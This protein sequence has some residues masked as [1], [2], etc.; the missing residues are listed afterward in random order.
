MSAAAH[1]THAGAA[2][3][4]GL[5]AVAPH[6]NVWDLLGAA[7]AEDKA[8]VEGADDEIEGKKDEKR[9]YENRPCPDAA[10][11][12]EEAALIDWILGTCV[13]QGVAQGAGGARVP[14]EH[15]LEVR[16]LV[17]KDGRAV[18]HV[19]TQEEDDR[20]ALGAICSGRVV[21]AVYGR[22]SRAIHKSQVIVSQTCENRIRDGSTHSRT[23]SIF[24]HNLVHARSR[25]HS[26]SVDKGAAHVDVI[27]EVISLCSSICKCLLLMG[28]P[29]GSKA[30]IGVHTVLTLCEDTN[31]PLELLS[32]FC[33]GQKAVV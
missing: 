27:R 17:H 21:N 19:G 33:L 7:S 16:R 20:L 2:N 10:V 28:I 32:L 13:S 15:V 1:A 4:N 24:F 12:T 22:V 11:A 9:E 8:L 6:V 29:V 5:E 26:P 30:Q 31:V 14:H 18:A 25:C 3:G 23:V